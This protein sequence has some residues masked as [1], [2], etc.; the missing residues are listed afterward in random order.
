MRDWVGRGPDRV[1]VSSADELAAAPLDAQWLGLFSR[2]HLSFAVERD[3]ASLEPTLSA[4]TVRAID[5]LAA[6]DSGYFLLVE[7]GRID[8]AHHAAR[9]GV[10]L[11]E[12]LEFNRAIEAALARVD[13]AETLILVTA[14]HAHTLT[15][16]G[17]PT[18]GNPILG[19]VTTNDARWY[20]PQRAPISPR[21]ASLTRR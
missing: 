19:F 9:A 3:A 4:M 18:R 15:I 2:S 6:R 20:R 1:F 5:N 14:D 13:L 17:Y 10:A 8:H 16:G 21:M 7:G 11:E 12:T